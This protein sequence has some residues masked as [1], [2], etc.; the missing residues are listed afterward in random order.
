MAS[1]VDCAAQAGQADVSS[2]EEVRAQLARIVESGE[3]RA[4][5][6]RARFLEYVVVRTLEGA[7]DT[8][9]EYTIGV[10]VFDRGPDF[11]PRAD[12]V[13]RTQAGLVRKHLERYYATEGL[14]DPIEIAL[15]KGHYVPR[16]QRRTPGSAP[17]AEPVMRPHRRLIQA[18]IAATARFRSAS[19]ST[20]TIATASLAA[21]PSNRRI[22][23]SRAGQTG[24]AAN[25]V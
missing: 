16:F 12:G 14:R 23:L 8:L 7:C 24:S 13:V 3:F 18:S 11:D 25:S 5:R 9:K 1:S 19:V 21:S 22:T 2:P 4:A 20:S 6:N 15:P 17:P 10:E